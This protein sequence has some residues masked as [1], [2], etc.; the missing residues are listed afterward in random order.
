MKLWTSS[1]AANDDRE[2][3]LAS[4]YDA[5]AADAG[6]SWANPARANARCAAAT[7]RCT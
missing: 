3:V 7:G 4:D 6:L 5:L 1:E 2:F